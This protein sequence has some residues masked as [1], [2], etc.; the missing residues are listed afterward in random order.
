MR[1]AAADALA[2][3][4]RSAARATGPTP[5]SSPPPA[6]R[7]CCS[8]RAA[9]APTRPRS[10]S[11]SPT[12]AAVARDAGRRRRRGVRMS[13]A[14]QPG[15]RPGRRAGAESTR[16]ARSTRALAG[17]APTPLRDLPAVAAELGV[18]AVAL[19]DESDRLGLP[20]FKVLGASWAVE[21]ALRERPGRRARSSRPARATTAARSPTRPRGAGC[22]ARVFL[23]ARVGRRAPRGDR[24]G[25]RRGRGGRRHLRGRGGAGGRRRRAADGVVEIADV[26][27]SGP[28]RWVIDGYATLFAEVAAQDAFDLVLVPAGV[29]SLAAAAARFGAACRRGSR[30]GSSP[31]IAACLTASLR[32]GRADRDPTRRAPRWPGWTAPRS[33]PPPGRRC[34]PAS[35]A[36]SPST[37]PR[38]TPRCASW[39]PSASRS[40]SA[41]R[42][43]WPRCARSSPTRPARRCATRSVSVRRTRVVLIATEGPT[44]PAGYLTALNADDV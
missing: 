28:A 37:T 24:G 5:R 23:P 35:P 30:S 10:G 33:R 22:A 32:G 34:G 18:G 39:P 42:R 41:A 3:R 40:A 26:G 9:R 12:P 25:G 2:R 19:K 14:R 21:R 1:D 29:G 38:R 8:G 27:D 4:R 13:G 36:R 11:A 31:T 17:Y 20:A 7:R 16:R 15:A 43:R 6:S 44:D